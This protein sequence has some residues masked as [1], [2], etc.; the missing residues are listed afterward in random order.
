L[1]DHF[2][3]SQAEKDRARR[4]YE[5]STVVDFLQASEFTDEYFHRVRSAGVSV[6]NKTVVGDE[7]LSDAMKLIADWRL[8]VARNSDVALDVFSIRDILGAK[9]Q[10]K[11]AY[12]RGFQNT[13]ALEGNVEMLN[14]YHKLGVYIIQL[15][16]NERNLIGT[17]CGEK[18]DEG[19]S[20]FGV[21][22]IERMNR[23]NMMVDLSHVGD[24]TTAQAIE[25]AR[26]PVV[27]H[28]NARTVCNNPRNKTDEQMKAVAEKDGVIGIVTF[29]SF[30]KWTKTEDGER[31]TIADVLDHVDYIVKLVG[32][33][34][35]GVGLDLIE[36]AEEKE[37]RG[38]IKRPDIWGKPNP[39][40]KNPFAYAVG[41]ESVSDLPNFAEGLV[42]RGYSDSEIAGILGGN[43]LRVVQRSVPS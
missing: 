17:G 7:N 11:V 16:Y 41:M 25:L 6:V 12:I 42:A 22:V 26:Y 29:P 43:W 14:L 28:S 37:Y 8:R 9:K 35:V 33:K 20:R 18:K 32:A 30:V 39:R 5:K 38:L 34:H 24:T 4:I 3:T 1:T 21:S 27:S 36:N 10:N 31:P 23:L 2:Q 15:T 19:L 13:L 40:L